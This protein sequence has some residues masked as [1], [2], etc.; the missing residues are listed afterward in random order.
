[1]YTGLEL[2]SATPE[3]VDHRLTPHT[4]NDFETPEFLPILV[5]MQGVGGE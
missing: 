5:I 4:Q 3:A 1:M 2:S